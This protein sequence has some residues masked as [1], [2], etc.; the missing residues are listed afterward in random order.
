MCG[1]GAGLGVSGEWLPA[2]PVELTGR[3]PPG[4]GCRLGHGL[5]AEEVEGE[6]TEEGRDA[7]LPQ[8]VQLDEL[9]HRA[10]ERRL[11][12]LHLGARWSRGLR[13]EAGHREDS[14]QHGGGLGLPLPLPSGPPMTGQGAVETLSYDA[15]GELL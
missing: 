5:A 7:V 8:Q 4:V 11:Q 10:R 13:G 6:G 1:P 12:Q 9:L 2:S 15:P 14:G 3:L